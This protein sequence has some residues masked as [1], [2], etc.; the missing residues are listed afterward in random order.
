MSRLTRCR[1]CSAQWY[2]TSALGPPHELCRACRKVAQLQ[3]EQPRSPT[4]EEWRALAMDR[5][6]WLGHR[7][8]E[9][10]DRNPWNTAMHAEHLSRSNS[11]V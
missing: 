2:V 1:A 10:G 9:A 8:W 3:A 6:V 7:G 11:D 5:E 4:L